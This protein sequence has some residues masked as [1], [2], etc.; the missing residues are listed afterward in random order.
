MIGEKKIYKIIMFSGSSFILLS[1]LALYSLFLRELYAEKERTL[2]SYKLLIEN[3]ILSDLNSI[4]DDLYLNLNT[5]QLIAKRYKEL[6][7][8]KADISLDVLADRFSQFE[9]WTN[10][11]KLSRYQKNIFFGANRIGKLNVEVQWGSDLTVLSVEKIV[12]KV[13]LPIASILIL[14]CIFFMHLKKKVIQPLVEKNTELA[15]HSAIAQTTQ[16]LAHDVRKPFTMVKSILDMMADSSAKDAKKIAEENISEVN[17][18]IRSVNGMI[19]DVMEIGSGSKIIQESA[20]LESMVLNVL[21]ENLRFIEKADVDISYKFL[22]KHQIYV[23][24]L[25]VERVLSNIIGNGLQAMQH[26]GNLWINSS[27]KDGFVTTTMGNSGSYIPPEDIVNLFEMFFTKGK[28]GGTGLGLAIA[29]KVVTAHGGTIWCTSD[30]EKG[31]EFHFTLPVTQSENTFDGAL[32]MTAKEIRTRFHSN[33]VEKTQESNLSGTKSAA[34]LVRSI[35]NAVEK[36]LKILVCDDESVYRNLL[37]RHIKSED[38]L[39]SKIEIS[40]VK[41]CREALS[42]AKEQNPDVIIMDVD[43]GKNEDNGFEVVRNLRA[44]GS[45]AKICMHSNRGAMEYQKD[46]VAAGADLFMPKPMTKSHL[47]SIILGSIPQRFEE[48][49]PEGDG[50]K[51]HYVVVDDSNLM[52]F[53][54]QQFQ[55]QLGCVKT[56]RSPEEFWA[57]AASD[58]NLLNYTKAVVTDQNFDEFS[59]K[60]GL[61]FADE[62]RASGFERPIYIASNGDFTDDELAKANLY[63]VPKSPKAAV[64]HVLS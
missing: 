31:T 29:K 51:G 6:F 21:N 47:L 16:M 5:T 14:W 59:E 58:E 56:F 38:E 41:N 40:T 26:K 49:L 61:E 46:A 64:E 34:A 55:T 23:D 63:R 42:M 57:A 54:W 32:P 39:I 25:K 12:I 13:G 45:T 48:I 28:K 24:T 60:T 36:P 15:K 37:E 8:G 2:E 33:M 43:L 9:G 62:L 17:Q 35:V 11:G 4:S 7:P 3:R 10:I 20:V 19:A 50:G 1:I 52:L 27:E 53:T 22:H 30:K 18:A 44:R